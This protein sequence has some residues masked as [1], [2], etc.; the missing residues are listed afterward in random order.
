VIEDSPAGVA[1]ALAA[2]MDVIAVTTDLTRQ[3][4]RETSLLERTRV[5]DDP[6][7]L[8]AVVRARIEEHR[9]G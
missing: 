8:P 3:K 1:A 6:R 4:F 2:G 9:R 7:R 5:V